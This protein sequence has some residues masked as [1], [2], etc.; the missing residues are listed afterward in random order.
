MPV[1]DTSR[2]ALEQLCMRDGE[3]IAKLSWRGEL[4]GL[5]DDF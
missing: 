1:N 3:P 5:K 2:H 4:L